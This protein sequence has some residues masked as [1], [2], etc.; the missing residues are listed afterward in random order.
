MKNYVF[1]YRN[2]TSTDDMPMDEVNA[3]WMNWFTELGDTVVDAGNPFNSGGQSV[4]QKG[5]TDVKGTATTGYSIIK[6]KGLDDA[7]AVA[8]TCPLVKHVADGEV[9]VYETLPM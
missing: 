2:D 6:A 5:A 3:A 9:Q 1:I 4:T 7:V 8:K